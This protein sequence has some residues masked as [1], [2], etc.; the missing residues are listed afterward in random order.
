MFSG[1]PRVRAATLE[2][3]WRKP[4]PN[5]LDDNQRGRF[6]AAVPPALTEVA[7]RANGFATDPLIIF[8]TSSRP[9]DLAQ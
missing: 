3:W 9:V 6:L 8:L 7:T 4:M 1:M 5:R 2:F